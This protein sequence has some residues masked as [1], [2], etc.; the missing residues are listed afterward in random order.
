MRI[1]MGW[2]EK[3]TGSGK[4]GGSWASTLLLVV[5]VKTEAARPG[6]RMIGR[7]FEAQEREAASKAED[8]TIK[9]SW[10]KET[11]INRDKTMLFFK[12]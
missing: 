5:A 9:T 12:T 11:E 1:E 4:K 8:A 7:Q 6:M 3:E 2:G 10:N